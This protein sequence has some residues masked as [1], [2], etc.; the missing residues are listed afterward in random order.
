MGKLPTVDEYLAAWEKVNT[1]AADTYRYLNFDQLPNYTGKAHTVTLS[2][3][4]VDAAK[5]LT[6]APPAAN[7]L[8]SNFF[9]R[10]TTTTAHTHGTHTHTLT[11]AL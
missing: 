10:P 5:K 11:L 1:D 8:R 3:E 9:T 4:M 2:P 7:A 6:S